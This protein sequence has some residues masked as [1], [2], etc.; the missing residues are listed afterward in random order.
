V[1]TPLLL[2]LSALALLGVLMLG[3]WALTSGTPDV[4]AREAPAPAA[5]PAAGSGAAGGR[6]DGQSQQAGDG[7][8]PADREQ[9]DASGAEAARARDLARRARQRI[10]LSGAAGSAAARRSAER[11]PQP[12]RRDD[13]AAAARR[14]AAEAQR[15]ADLRRAEQLRQAE[16]ARQAAEERAEDAMRAENAPEV[17]ESGGE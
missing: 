15:L 8:Q 16:L 13:Q 5:G 2:V 3:G 7:A 4:P 17:G 11:R 1:R 6:V 9:E 10:P 12:L 14:R